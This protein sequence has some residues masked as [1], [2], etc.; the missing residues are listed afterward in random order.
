MF[1]SGGGATRSLGASI[2]P[3][4]SRMS[5]QPAKEEG[6]GGALTGTLFV[7]NTTGGGGAPSRKAAELLLS[8]IERGAARARAVSLRPSDLRDG[9]VRAALLSRGLTRL[10]A[11]RPEGG[12]PLLGLAAIESRLRPPARPEPNEEE[13]AG[14]ALEEYMQAQLKGDA[15]G[16]REFLGGAI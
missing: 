5:R 12:P 16:D 9:G 4:R 8:A 3:R 7:L 6:P 10:P 1:K 15:S 13:A 2:P 11:F 14:E